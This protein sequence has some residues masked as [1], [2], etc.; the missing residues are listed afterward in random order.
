MQEERVPLPREQ[1][2]EPGAS[3]GPAAGPAAAASDRAA[4]R[5]R[6]MD[7]RS[8]FS[9][10]ADSSHEQRAGEADPGDHRQRQRILGT[11]QRADARRVCVADEVL[12]V[13]LDD[14]ADG[15]DGE[16]PSPCPPRERV[17]PISDPPPIGAEVGGLLAERT[18]VDGDREQGGEAHERQD[19]AGE[20]Q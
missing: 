7:S 9:S 3:I 15:D 4:R 19:S 11:N 6:A 12:D 17:C 16:Q 10:L 8:R 18:E 20:S 2:S 14:E 1:G 5:A 13:L